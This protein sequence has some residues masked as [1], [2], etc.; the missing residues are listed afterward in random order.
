MWLRRFVIF[1]HVV[2]LLLLAVGSLCC[3]MSHR[4]PV[5][6]PLCLTLNF[7][8]SVLGHGD[9]ASR[10][11]FERVPFPSGVKIKG[12]ASSETFVLAFSGEHFPRPFV[13]PPPSAFSENGCFSWGS[14][15]HCQLGHG[16]STPTLL[17]PKEILAFKGVLFFSFSHP[18]DRL[19][20]S[21]FF[22]QK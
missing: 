18:Q 6:I 9:S 10:I 4:A 20:G 14:N 5:I 16:A 3:D 2:L 17:Q 7:T 19:C 12:I 1:L 11:L 22:P 8:D 13:K 15:S 21:F